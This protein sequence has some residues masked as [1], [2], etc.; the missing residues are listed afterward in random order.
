MVWRA[1]NIF[2]NQ[3]FPNLSFL[4]IPS[5][6]FASSCISRLFSGAVLLC[7]THVLGSTS[8]IHFKVGKELKTRM[9][10]QGSSCNLPA[11]VRVCCPAWSLADGPRQVPKHLLA[12]RLPALCFAPGQWALLQLCL[13]AHCTARFQTRALLADCHSLPCGNQNKKH[14]R[15]KLAK[16]SM[17]SSVGIFSL[18]LEGQFL[19]STLLLQS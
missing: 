10:V 15:A 9:G 19:T 12:K 4:V 14:G 3:Q 2:S 1:R 18:T 13:S 11:G 5:N 6:R 7:M 16:G 17:V 8:Q